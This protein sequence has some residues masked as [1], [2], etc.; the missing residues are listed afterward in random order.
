M[1]RKTLYKRIRWAILLT[2][3]VMAIIIVVLA[4]TIEYHL[5]LKDFITQ[6][7]KMYL[8]SSFVVIILVF[9]LKKKEKKLDE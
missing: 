1:K 6:C 7:T 5:E 3:T 8:V 4:L 9:F 2:W